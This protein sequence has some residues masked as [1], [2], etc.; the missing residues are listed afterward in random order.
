VEELK[1]QLEAKGFI[2]SAEVLHHLA[3]LSAE[4]K[5]NLDEALSYKQ[6]LYVAVCSVEAELCRVLSVFFV[7]CIAVLIQCVNTIAI[8]LTVVVTSV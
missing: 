2:P 1:A 4:Y 6:R 3:T 5:H 8:F 7:Q